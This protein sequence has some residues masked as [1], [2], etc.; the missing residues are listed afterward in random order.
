MSHVTPTD[1]IAA[2]ALHLVRAHR[3]ADR[4]RGNADEMR[5]L[6]PDVAASWDAYAAEATATAEAL[7]D[8]IETIYGAEITG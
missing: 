2:C 7:M 1:R 4:C 5:T 3:K 8:E 6:A